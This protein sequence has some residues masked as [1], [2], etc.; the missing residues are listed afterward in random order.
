MVNVCTGLGRVIKACPRDC[1]GNMSGVPQ[2]AADLLHYQSRQSRGMHR[3]NP[4]SQPL[5]GKQHRNRRQRASGR[6]LLRREPTGL[7][8]EEGGVVTRV[9]CTRTME[10]IVVFGNDR[11]R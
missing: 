11:G 8:R 9:S 2:I 4:P 1:G 7:T 3:S 5:G 6:A 10:I